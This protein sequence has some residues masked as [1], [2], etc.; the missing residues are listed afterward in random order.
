MNDLSRQLF[1]AV[2][3]KNMKVISIIL[4][5]KPPP[6]DLFVHSNNSGMNTLM[7]AVQ[8]I[9][10]EDAHKFTM[11]L[12]AL[13]DSP[14]PIDAVNK[15]GQTALMIAAKRGYGLV[16][17]ALLDAKANYDIKTPVCHNAYIAITI[18]FT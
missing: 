3:D 6:L 8:L 4:S 5:T 17:K 7:M 12:L 2:S 11:L 13:K 16:V 14:V 10:E 9:P 15:L 1:Q 18:K